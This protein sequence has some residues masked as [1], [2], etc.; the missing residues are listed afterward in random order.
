M[1]FYTVAGSV[2]VVDVL[3]GDVNGD[4]SLDTLDRLT[5]SRYLANWQGYTIDDINTIGADVNS[6][7]SVDTLDRLIL[8]RHLANWS[9]YEDITNPPT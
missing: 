7:G 2:D 6:D 8:S 5:L 3:I 4:G 9:G 1:K